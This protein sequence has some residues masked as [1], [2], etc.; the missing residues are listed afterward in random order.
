MAKQ[1]EAILTDGKPRTI[2]V[3]ADLNLDD[4]YEVQKWTQERE[5]EWLPAEE[6]SSLVRRDSVIEF[7][8]IEAVEP[9]TTG[10]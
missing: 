7:H 6:G 5:Q 1:L 8:V 2:Q 9:F 4:M 10:M 3:P